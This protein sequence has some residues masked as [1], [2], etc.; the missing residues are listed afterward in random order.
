MLDDKFGDKK[1]GSLATE[2]VH[3]FFLEIAFPRLWFEDIYICKD[4]ERFLTHHEMYQLARSFNDRICFLLNYAPVFWNPLLFLQIFWR[5]LCQNQ[6]QCESD[7]SV[8][9]QSSW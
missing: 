4:R 8:N 7:A 1:L 2:F 9:K 6:T 5:C 3:I